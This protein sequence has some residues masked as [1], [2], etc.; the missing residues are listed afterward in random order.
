M[1]I[2]LLVCLMLLTGSTLMLFAALGLVRFGDALGRAHA[3][4]KASTFGICLLLLALW[5]S[6]DDDVS[7]LKLVLVIAFS[8]LTIPVASHLVAFLMHRRRREEDEPEDDTTR[9]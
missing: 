8:L 2:D 5:V 9:C 6:L 1:L 4:S 3:L 7:K